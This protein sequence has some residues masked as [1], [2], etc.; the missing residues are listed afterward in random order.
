MTSEQSK[1][2]PR[3]I[4]IAIEHHQA[5][6][7]VQERVESSDHVLFHDLA[8]VR[9]PEKFLIGITG[10]ADAAAQTLASA[11]EKA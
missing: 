9:A 2:L 11:R 5:G 1:G 8:S 4:E 6:Q 10:Q 7:L 3:A